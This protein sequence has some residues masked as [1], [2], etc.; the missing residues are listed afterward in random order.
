ML[1]ELGL[2]VGMKAIVVPVL[3]NYL[4]SRFNGIPFCVPASFGIDSAS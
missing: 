1:A 2:L 3:K 4:K